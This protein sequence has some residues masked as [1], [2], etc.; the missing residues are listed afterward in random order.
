[1]SLL[2]R[3][4]RAR[5]GGEGEPQVPSA[6]QT[7]PVPSGGGAGDTAAPTQPPTDTL[8]S[9]GSGPSD[10]AWLLAVGLGVLL[11]SIVVLTPARVKSR[12]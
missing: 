12:R 7:T 5:P 10:G 4:E 2:K 9:N 8:S 6:P 3:I 11:A 1:M